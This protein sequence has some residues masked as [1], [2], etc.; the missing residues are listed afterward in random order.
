MADVS[1]IVPVY[2]SE[3]YL[4]ECLDSILA[5]SFRDF[6]LILVDDG[7]SDGSGGICEEYQ[8]SD[9]RVRLIRQANSGQSAARN[10]GVSESS[11]GL[12]CFIDSDDAVNPCLLESFLNVMRENDAGAVTCERVRGIN[13]PEGFYGPVTPGSEMIGINEQTLYSLHKENNTVYW[14]LFP[15]LI[16]KSIYEKYPLTPG[17][18]MEDNAVA[19]KWLAG[20]GRVAVVHAPLYFYRENPNGTMNSAFSEKK[21]DFLWAL[22]QQMDFYKELDY[23]LMLGAIANQYLDNAVWFAQRARDELKDER[24]A[25]KILKDAADTLR[26]YDCADSLTDADRRK[27]FKALHPF[28]YKVKKS[29]KTMR[30]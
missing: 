2:N 22:K 19:C 14:T 24:L 13:P 27:L 23:K 11:C 30:R 20:A 21:L 16:K 12:I 5:Q 25:K 29:L 28:M 3:E 4:R 15:C 7:S 26:R 6:E 10:R 17:R 8:S 18:V 1:V 9:S